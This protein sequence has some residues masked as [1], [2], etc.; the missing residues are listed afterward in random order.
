MRRRRNRELPDSAAVQ[1]S[2]SMPFY[3]YGGTGYKGRLVYFAAFKK[4]ISV[5]LPYAGLLPKELARKIEKYH[6][7]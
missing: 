4:H 6:V 7:G 2:N 3:E 5:F 1:R